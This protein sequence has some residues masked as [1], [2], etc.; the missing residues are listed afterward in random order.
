MSALPRL[1]PL[2]H[3]APALL[4]VEAR[5]VALQG[6]RAVLDDGRSLPL[7]ASCLLQPQPGDRV[8]ATT[9][10]GEGWILAV[11]TRSAGGTAHLTVPGA[12]SLHLSQATVRIEASQSLALHS[13]RDAEL[14]AATGTLNLAARNLFTTVLETV[15]ERA[16]DKLSKFGSFALE[17]ATL[18]RLHSRHGVITADKHIRVDADQIHM[19]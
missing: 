5:V 12:E 17:A 15:V 2:P 7:A 9:G 10:G 19:G 16:A 4:G 6:G 3:P 14:T 11:L 18:L 1:L 13:R 8:L